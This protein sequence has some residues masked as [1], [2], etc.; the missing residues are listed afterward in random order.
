M[1]FF[2]QKYARLRVSATHVIKLF[3]AVSLRVG[4]DFR[5]RA[6]SGSRFV[7]EPDQFRERF[8]FGDV[9]TYLFDMAK[10]LDTLGSC[11]WRWSR[12][13]PVRCARP[14]SGD[15]D[16]ICI[17]VR[18]PEM[19]ERERKSVSAG[20]RCIDNDM[21]KFHFLSFQRLLALRWNFDKREDWFFKEKLPSLSV[22]VP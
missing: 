2:A 9:S 10:I 7:I 16:D 6:G 15:A 19:E 1:I 5:W 13:R 20:C 18:T 11:P 22:D 14:F 8:F 12:F 3:L 21:G 17:V 4:F